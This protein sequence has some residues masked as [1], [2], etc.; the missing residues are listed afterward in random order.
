M[1]RR[2]AEGAA[3]CKR[4]HRFTPTTPSELAAAQSASNFFMHMHN[5]QPMGVI[6]KNWIRR[7]IGQNELQFIPDMK[8][9]A[10]IFISKKEYIDFITHPKVEYK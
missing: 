5:V 9:A 7:R 10:I 3:L 4:G 8:L 6:D 1:Q 2:L